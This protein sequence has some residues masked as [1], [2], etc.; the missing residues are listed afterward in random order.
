MNRVYFRDAQAIGHRRAG[1]RATSRSYRNAQLCAGGIDKVLHNQEVSGETHRLHDVQFKDQTFLH[2]V[3]QGITVQLLGTVECQLCQIVGFQL[4][5]V[6][7]V[8]APQTLYLGIGGIL[9]QHH[10]AVFILGKLIK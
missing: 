9:I 2:L 7:F 8:V 4:D 3:G 10:L 1:S 5:T 6:Q